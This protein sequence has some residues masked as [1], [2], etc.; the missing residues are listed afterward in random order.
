MRARV[1]ELADSQLRITIEGAFGWLTQVWGM[2]RKQIPK[3]YTLKK[4]MAVVSCSYL[5][6]AMFNL[7]VLI[8]NTSVQCSIY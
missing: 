3:A 5:S 1:F 7:L 8:S 2:V 4:I 6:F